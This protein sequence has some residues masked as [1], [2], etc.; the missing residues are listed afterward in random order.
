[1]VDNEPLLPM[2]GVCVL[3]E[4][5]GGSTYMYAFGSVLALPVSKQALSLNIR[6]NGKQSSWHP[7]S[8]AQHFMN[9]LTQD[10][11]TLL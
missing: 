8:W 1:M 6:N 9:I 3:A 4:R 2:L 11:A 7:K 5:A 10:A